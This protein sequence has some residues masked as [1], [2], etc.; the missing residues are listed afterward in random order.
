MGHGPA[1]LLEYQLDTK[2]IISLVYIGSMGISQQE[3]PYITARPKVEH[4]NT[5]TNRVKFSG[6]K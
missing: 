2:T 4:S 3:Q 6:K 5:A 1:L